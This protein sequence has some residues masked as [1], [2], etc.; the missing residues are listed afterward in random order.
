MSSISSNINLRQL[1]SEIRTFKGASG[2]IECL[3]IPIVANHLVKG[4]K[5]VYL[6]LTGFEIKERK[7]DRKDT[8]LVKQSFPKEIYDAMTD[9]Q[10]QAAPILGNHTVWGHQEPAPQE[11]AAGDMAPDPE[12]NDLPF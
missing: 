2:N 6:N 7:A 9:E 10:K 12:E 5:G 1:K 8:H 4:E 3:V 11:F